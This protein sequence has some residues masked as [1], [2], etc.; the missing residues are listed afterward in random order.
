MLSR[1]DMHPYQLRAV[2]F[3]K[4]KRRAFLMLDLGLGK[5][6]TTMTAVSDLMDGF[7]VRKVL[8]IAPL[9]VANSVWMQ[10]AARW[11]HLRHLT[12]RVCT[13]SAKQRDT[14]LHRT[15]DVYVINRENVEWL[16]TRYGDRWP[17]DCIVVDESSSFKNPSARRFKA[18]RKILPHTSYMILLS[19][20]PSPNGVADLW[21]QC[22]LIDSGMALGRTV[23]MF[24]QRYFEQDYNRFGYRPKDGAA[25]QIRDKIAPFC[26]SMSATDYLTVPD[27]IVVLHNVTLPVPIMDKYQQFERD[28][29][30]EHDGIE[31]EAVNAAVM[32][33]KLLQ[34]CIAEGTPVVT[35]RGLV[36]IESVSSDDLIWDGEF[37]V[38]CY[39]SVYKGNKDVVNCYGVRMT[40]E[41]KVLTTNGWKTAKE[42]LDGKSTERFDRERLRNPNRFTKYW[43]KERQSDLVM[44]MHMREK[45]GT[46]KPEST[47]ETQVEG[48]EIL[49]VSPWKVENLSR[50][51][52]HKSIQYLERYDFSMQQPKRQGLQKLRCPWDKCLQRLGEI[53]RSFLGGYANR[54]FRPFDIRS[55][56]QFFGLFKGKLSLGNTK[57]TGSKYSQNQ[58]HMDT[59]RGNVCHGCCGKVRSE[60]CDATCEGF[61]VQMAERKMVPSAKVYDL[62]NCG[63]NNRF[64]VVGDDGELLIVHNCNGAM[65]TG[66]PGTGDYVTIHDDKIDA[67]KDIIEDNAG[68]NILVAYSFKSDLERLQ[69]A[70]P[71]AR[72]LDK[73]PDTID[74]WNNGEIPLLLAHPQSAGYGLN[75]QRGG[76]VIVWFSL[77]WSLEYYLQFNA[78]LHRQGQGRPV[79]IIHIVC[80]GT[81]DET[82][83]KVLSAKDADQH[84]LLAALKES[85]PPECLHALI[86]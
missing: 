25:E 72:V 82:V 2:N 27:K 42:V 53:I 29:F 26:L 46:A 73:N 22:Y 28:L 71:G 77:P 68:K 43:L 3:I 39:G 34:M 4:D 38:N 18:L 64:T 44:P 85:A 5:T 12:I 52:A 54:I 51:D 74:Q 47:F 33:G 56:G 66:L 24:R 37:F 8:I 80:G 49:R 65:Y 78:R 14:V 9:R 30:L 7:A 15:A 83:H 17:F 58:N 62:V 79:R 20:T 60:C 59:E 1:D 21:A 23:T 84:A 61:Q 55:N 86:K 41:H 81:I 6:V 40:E 50:N 31:I 36:P 45:G 35:A 75:L 19:G 16:V 48:R 11:E 32:A 13:G 76:A 69:A 57:T 70:F 63:K 67:L 10:E